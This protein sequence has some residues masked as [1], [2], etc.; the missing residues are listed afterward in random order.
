MR[1]NCNNLTFF[2]RLNTA[3][4]ILLLVTT[5]R[6]WSQSTYESYEKNTDSI[7]TKLP[8]YVGIVRLGGAFSLPLGDNAYNKNV[9]YEKGYAFALSFINSKNIFA[10][11]TIDV[12]KYTV[13][14][15]E[16]FGPFDRFRRNAWGAELAHQAR[17]TP[18]FNIYPSLS[19]AYVRYRYD[20]DIINESNKNG[21]VFIKLKPQEASEFKVGFYG[22][23]KITHAWYVYVGTHYQTTRIQIRTARQLE[24]F[25]D[26][27]SGF[28]F[29]VGM[30]VHIN[31][32]RGHKR[33]QARR[34]REALFKAYNTKQK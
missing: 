1:S 18:R 27:A 6:S 21:D 3:V 4:A 5:T 25:L 33:R 26:S 13:I 7:S 20:S 16:N 29:Q 10:F 2:T 30:S 8:I 32:S 22:E 12:A 31:L 9:A 19:V 11:F 28:Q 15:Q 24:D 14:S 17:I 23:Y 34:Q